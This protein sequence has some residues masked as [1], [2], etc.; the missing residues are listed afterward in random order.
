MGELDN[1]GD[2][3]VD[4][5]GDAQLV[6]HSSDQDYAA[7]Y[8]RAQHALGNDLWPLRLYPLWPG[9]LT[10][11]RLPTRDAAILEFR[12]GCLHWHVV[13][14]ALAATARRVN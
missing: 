13:A 10:R 6:A 5:S 1:P 2:C 9:P 4:H 11:C 12:R 3:A 14:P 7:Q 8:A